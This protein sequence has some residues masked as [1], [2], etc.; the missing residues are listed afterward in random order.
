MCFWRQTGKNLEYQVG[1]IAV[2]KGYTSGANVVMERGKLNRTG[3]ATV[4]R[5][6]PKELQ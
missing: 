4:C 5:I 3:M 6:N 1:Q 2:P